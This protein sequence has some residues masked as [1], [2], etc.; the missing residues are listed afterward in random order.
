MPQVPGKCRGRAY[1]FEILSFGHS[2]YTKHSVEGG[3]A[4]PPLT[5]PRPASTIRP[6]NETVAP[7]GLTMPRTK[8]DPAPIPKPSHPTTPNACPHAKVFR[9]RSPAREP[10]V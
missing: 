9:H 2:Q 10:L 6:P 4:R 8:G 7:T 1:S 5:R 3:E